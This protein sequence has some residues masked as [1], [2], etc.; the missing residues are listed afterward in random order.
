MS[1]NR[2]E[3]INVLVS[4]TEHMAIRI[5]AERNGEKVGPFLR[6]LA[7][8]EIERQ[9][10]PAYA[11]FGICE[12]CGH[13]CAPGTSI[14]ES[15]KAERK[16]PMTIEPAIKRAIAEKVVEQAHPGYSKAAQGQWFTDGKRLYHA[17][18]Q[19]PWNP[20]PDNASV[21]SVDELVQH[22]GGAEKDHARFETED[23]VSGV[24][25]EEATEIAVDFC[26]QYIPDQIIVED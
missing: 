25:E 20:W 13:P 16:Q 9:S 10:R 17:A 12:T 24:S 26:L 3:M 2:T 1:N 8:Q 23:G 22:Y 4:P 18:E 7:L 11:N 21:V 14:H 15:C 19:R 6:R 5:L